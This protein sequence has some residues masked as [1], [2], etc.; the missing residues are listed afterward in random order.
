MKKGIYITL[1]FLMLAFKL[2]A[3]N[4]RVYGIFRTAE[5]F[6]E[7]KPNFEID[8]RQTRT[9]IKLN[10]FFEKPYLTVKDNDS[11]YNFY[12]R[13]IYGYLTC[14]NEVYRFQNKKEL[15]LLN[16]PEQIFIYEYSIKPREGKTNATNYYFSLGAKGIIQKLTTK[17]LKAAFPLNKNFQ[18]LIEKSFRYN[19]E[20]ASFDDEHKM[21]R[22]NFLLKK[23]Q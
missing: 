13:D 21:Y 12:K 10:D 15:L 6:I 20:L 22:I 17:K 11:S 7:G 3:Q 8:C 5:D 19:T 16:K 9:K 2:L 4:E 14:S 1:F 18:L 23:C